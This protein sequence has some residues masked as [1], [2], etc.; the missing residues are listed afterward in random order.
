[1]T[2]STSP[3]HTDLHAASS[4][5]TPD[6]TPAPHLAHEVVEALEELRD[7]CDAQSEGAWVWRYEGDGSKEERSFHLGASVLVHGDEVG[8]L[9]GLLDVIKALQSGELSFKGRFSCFVGNPKAAYQGVRFTEE[10][11]NRVFRA[12]QGD[13]N[14]LSYEAKRAA[15]LTPLLDELDL[16]IDFHQTILPVAQPFY[17]CPWEVDTWRWARLMGGAQVW[18]TRHPQRGGGGLACADAWV[19]ARGKPSLALELGACGVSE[20]ARS[21]VWSSLSRAMSAADLLSAH[22]ATLS[23][24]AEEQPDLQFFETSTRVSLN[25]PHMALKEGLINFMPV[26][27]GEVLSPEGAAHPI[28]APMSGALLFPKYPSRDTSGAAI[29]PYPSELFR[30]VTPLQGHPTQLWPEL[31]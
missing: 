21:A 19:A 17:I 30:V 23:T 11:L 16:Y 4:T 14:E 9:L 1:M 8:P 27:Q 31:M 2:M 20:A 7:L 29:S 15:E 26:T 25:N 18:V 12:P 13:V 24:L 3:L 22:H 5:N 28:Q 6:L 10:D